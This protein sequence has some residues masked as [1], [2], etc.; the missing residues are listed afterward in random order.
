MCDKEVKD[1][2]ETSPEEMQ[3]LREIVISIKNDPEAMR[4]AKLLTAI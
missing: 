2:K 3:K 4:Q 1:E